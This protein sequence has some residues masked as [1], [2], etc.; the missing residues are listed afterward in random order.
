MNILSLAQVCQIIA[1]S[2]AVFLAVIFVAGCTR[3]LMPT[4]NAYASQKQPLLEALNPELEGN[5]VDF[6]Y[7]TDRLR[8]DDYAEGPDYVADA[9]GS[10]FG[11]M[12]MY[13]NA[14]DR[15]IGAA[16]ALFTSRVRLG[17]VEPEELT[18]TQKQA[19]RRVANLDIIIYRGQ[20]AG[21]WGHSYFLDNP[22]VSSDILLLLRY[23]W[24]PGEAGRRPLKPLGA[25]FWAIDDDYLD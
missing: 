4:P 15:A 24:A 18:E 3:T 9:L 10:G 20:A 11:R 5:V 12:T 1:G 8:V 22:A 17:S 14:N 25:Q 19:L 13:T 23:G 2:V 21:S 7:V 6:L 16:Q